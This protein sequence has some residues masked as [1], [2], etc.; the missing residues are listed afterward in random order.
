MHAV[1]AGCALDLL[2][3]W[4]E[5]CDWTRQLGHP[6]RMRATT[7]RATPLCTPGAANPAQSPKSADPSSLFPASST[8]QPGAHSVGS[9]RRDCTVAALEWN[10]GLGWDGE[11]WGMGGGDRP[12]TGPMHWKSGQHILMKAPCRGMVVT[13]ADHA[14]TVM[15]KRVPEQQIPVLMGCARVRCCEL[16]AAER[17]PMVPGITP[18]SA[19]MSW[20]VA[21]LGAGGT[22]P[23]RFAICT[24]PT[25][26]KCRQTKVPCET[27]LQGKLFSLPGP[28]Q[29]HNRCIES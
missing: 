29:G 28:L 17:T 1:M 8:V 24:V 22:S 3:P 26:A 6:G 11:G 14:S 21:R 5:A 20:I 12:V 2:S 27:R 19:A 13:N 16:D 15:A 10:G 18:S 23:P 7:P 4:A 9:G 25:E